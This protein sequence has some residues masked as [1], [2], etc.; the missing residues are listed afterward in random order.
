MAM[1]DW[2]IKLVPVPSDGSCFFSS[3][4]VALNRSTAVWTGD[5]IIRHRLCVYW[6]EYLA[7]GL[8]AEA[9]D[10]FTPGCMRY[11]ASV[12]ID[13][14]DLVSYNENARADGKKTFGTAE[15]LAEHVLRSKC[16][17]DST[18]FGAFLK[19]LDCSVSLVVLDRSV[20][21]PLHMFEELVRDKTFYIC[22]S[23]EN[24]HYQ[25]IQL[26]YRGVS[27]PFCVRR[28]TIR[29]FMQDCFP[30]RENNF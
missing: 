12:N 6:Q 19:S 2:A 7:L 1:T 21:E 8:E 23:L 16:W 30:S 28:K 3:V 26:V 5:E 9:P 29:K 4:A 10:Y 15:S 13:D 20:P 27:L 25:P 11:M 22:L 18:T 24:D 14:G 17:V